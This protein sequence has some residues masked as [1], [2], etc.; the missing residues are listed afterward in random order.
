MPTP[1]AQPKPLPGVRKVVAVASGK[2]G[3]GKSTVA[4]NLALA[5]KAEGLKAGILDADIYGPSQPLML[6]SKDRP[7]SPDGKLMNPIRAHG[8]Q[9]MSIGFLIDED[10]PMIW[11]GPMVTQALAQM[12]AETVWDDLDVLVIDLPPGTG[13]AALTLTQMAPLSGAVIVTTANDLSLIRAVSSPAIP[14]VRVSSCTIRTLLVFLTV[15]MIASSS[16]GA[17]D[18]RSTTSTESP[19]SIS[20]CSAA[21]SDFHT[22]AAYVMIET[23]LPSRAVRALPIGVT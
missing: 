6:G 13:D 5:F 8:L 1:H 19:S 14:P 20:S 3:V 2:G 4:V 7:T 23:S 17:I 21:S 16:I 10:Q 9:A 11:R 12:L 18:L 15:A 22:V